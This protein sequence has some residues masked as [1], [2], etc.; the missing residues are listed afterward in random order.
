MMME[1][2]KAEE[3]CA[4][5]LFPPKLSHFSNHSCH[6]W[7]CHSWVLP[8]LPLLPQRSINVPLY[9]R[10]LTVRTVRL[11]QEM[12]GKA[13]DHITLGALPFFLVSSISK[14]FL[15]SVTRHH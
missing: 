9:I 14:Q 4:E 8:L 10:N 2:G 13:K 12:R 6:F 11:L 1:R 15:L 5:R 3:A 7:S